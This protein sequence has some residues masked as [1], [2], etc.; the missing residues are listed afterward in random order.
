MFLSPINS[1]FLP[2]LR[3]R[4][5]GHAGHVSQ[6]HNG[7][8]K[9]L[10]GPPPERGPRDDDLS[11]LLTALLGLTFSCHHCCCISASCSGR[12]HS[13]PSTCPG[14][15]LLDTLPWPPTTY[16]KKAHAPQLS[17]ERSQPVAVL[18]PPS[19]LAP[20]MIPQPSPSDSSLFPPG[21]R[22]FDHTRSPAEAPGLRWVLNHRLH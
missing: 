4:N 15:S 5:S 2:L 17:V 14:P 10:G 12:P 1:S 19:P 6:C 16:R 11:A 22:T 8:Q 9:R 21:P 13:T 18:A 3:S 20:F 7:G